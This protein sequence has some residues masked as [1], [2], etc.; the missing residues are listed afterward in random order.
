M[1]F[2]LAATFAIELCHGQLSPLGL[3]K[4]FRL[5]SLLEIIV[6]YLYDHPFTLIF[7]Y[8]FDYSFRVHQKRLWYGLIRDNITG[9]LLPDLTHFRQNVQKHGIAQMKGVNFSTNMIISNQNHKIYPSKCLIE[10]CN[11]RVLSS[12]CILFTCVLCFPFFFLAG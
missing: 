12:P 5:F 8:N 2:E 3:C 11:P 1:C 7:V 6:L 4:T 9:S 10:F